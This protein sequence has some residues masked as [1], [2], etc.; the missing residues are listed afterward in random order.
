MM[1]STPA[2]RK[3]L[4]D[5]LVEALHN[6]PNNKELKDALDIVDD[7]IK[8]HKELQNK[9]AVYVLYDTTKNTIYFYKPSDMSI[10]GEYDWDGDGQ[11]LGIVLEETL[12]L[13]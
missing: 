3:I 10:I 2:S 9:Y 7:L 5:R 8:Y 4:R 13:P 12:Y 6:T 11:D 1:K